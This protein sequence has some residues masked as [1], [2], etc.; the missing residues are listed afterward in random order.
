MKKNFRRS[1]LFFGLITLGLFLGGIF[2]ARPEQAFACGG[3]GVV[4]ASKSSYAIGDDL[5]AT[6]F[7]GS[8]GAC[9]GNT[10]KINLR[11]AVGGQA[12]D[13]YAATCPS[14]NQ[15]D[16]YCVVNGNTYQLHVAQRSYFTVP[17]NGNF[18]AEIFVDNVL[19]QKTP[20]LTVTVAGNTNAAPQSESTQ[21]KPIE[22][23]LTVAISGLTQ[24]ANIALYISTLYTYGLQ[25][26]G[27]LAIFM[28]IIGGIKY[29]TAGGDTGRT[30][31][32][33]QNITNA[34]IGLVFALAT[35]LILNTINPELLKFKPPAIDTVQRQ[36]LTTETWCEDILSYD[37]NVAGVEPT[38]G[39]CNTKGTLVAKPGTKLVKTDCIFKTCPAGLACS[40]DAR[41]AYSCSKCEDF[42]KERLQKEFGSGGIAGPGDADC[43][44]RGPYRNDSG[45]YVACVYSNEAGYGDKGC[46]ILNVD[47][48]NIQTCEDYTRYVA[49]SDGKGKTFG[50]AYERSCPGDTTVAGV[51]W[52][53]T[54]LSV[55]SGGHLAEVC[56]A[57]PCLKKIGHACESKVN[58]SISEFEKTIGN[59]SPFF[60]TALEY[61]CTPGTDCTPPKPT[62]PAGYDENYPVPG[63]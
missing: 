52:A 55:K 48:K 22:T 29:L 30:K 21:P 2:L 44:P 24:T 60:D 14:A 3:S 26:V 37:A 53:G 58:T 20:P 62:P 41:G 5:D 50:A 1:P 61:C 33:I 45:G 39:T 46:R 9:G 54:V 23:R 32:A 40:K 19:L 47:C 57:N 10:V 15:N 12:Y 43:R 8:D 11:Y 13:V 42:T 27:L 25:I 36:T 18:E 28:I 6:V 38:S 34:T 49:L 63:P 56:N 16:T 4:K 59:A 7:F 51:C 31:S 35:Y 17:G